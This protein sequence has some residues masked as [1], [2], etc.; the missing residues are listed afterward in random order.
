MGS[1]PGISHPP[2]WS[3]SKSA[4]SWTLCLGSIRRTPSSSFIVP[5]ASDGQGTWPT[6][7][8]S[9]FAVTCPRIPLKKLEWFRSYRPG[10]VQTP[11]QLVD[12]MILSNMI[13]QDIIEK[14]EKQNQCQK[15]V[16]KELKGQRS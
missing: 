12:G 1:G 15:E 8:Q 5:E 2:C 4:F 6:A 13:M 14:C 16:Q 9:S 7:S 11:E 3:R 10:C